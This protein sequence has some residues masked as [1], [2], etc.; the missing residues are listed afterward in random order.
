ML[1]S[2]TRRNHSGLYFTTIRQMTDTLVILKGSI[3]M[4]SRRRR[5]FLEKI[6]RVPVPDFL[7][8]CARTNWVRD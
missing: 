2:F 4:I 3:R 7:G 8:D 1:L 5:E 6:S